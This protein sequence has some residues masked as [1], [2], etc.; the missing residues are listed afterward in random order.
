MASKIEEWRFLTR[1]SCVRGPVAAFAIV[2]LFAFS[3]FE[4][5]SLMIVKTWTG[6][7]FDAHAGGLALSE[8][9]RRVLGPLLCEAAA[10][11]IAVFMLRGQRTVASRRAAPSRATDL[12]GWCYLITAFVFVTF[13][14]ASMVLCGMIRGLNLLS[15]ISCS[16]AKL[17][18]ACCLRPARRCSRVWALFGCIR[19]GAAGGPLLFAP[20]S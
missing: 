9:F 13:I 2:F 17:F 18:R 14:P 8:S 16:G 15:G 4:M 3:E 5:A 10:V 20:W 12:F 1:A 11:A 6:S 19:Q 7:L